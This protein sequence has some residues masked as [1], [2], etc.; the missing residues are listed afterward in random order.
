MSSRNLNKPDSR[1][2]IF[3]KEIDKRI[4]EGK[5]F[6]SE[7]TEEEESTDSGIGLPGGLITGNGQPDL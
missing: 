1:E 4:Q 2:N 5:R 3:K 7:V 6:D